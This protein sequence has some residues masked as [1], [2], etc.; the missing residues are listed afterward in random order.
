M[1]DIANLPPKIVS[2][3]VV[4]LRTALEVAAK[5]MDQDRIRR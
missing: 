1:T 4:D 3:D 2:K 5:R